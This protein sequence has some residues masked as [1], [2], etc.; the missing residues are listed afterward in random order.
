MSPTPS[1]G[2]AA[3]NSDYHLIVLVEDDTP[4][5]QQL[6][7]PRPYLSSSHGDD[8]AGNDPLLT[9]NLSASFSGTNQSGG[10]EHYLFLRDT[11]DLPPR[12]GSSGG[13]NSV[14]QV[15]EVFVLTVIALVGIVGN[16]LIAF[17][18]IRRKQLKYPSNR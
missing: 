15:A 12:Y 16:L 8:D 10:S 9:A 6:D 11:P 18:L 3:V 14:N 7:L 4:P 13:G 5:E 17:T 2:A 1:P